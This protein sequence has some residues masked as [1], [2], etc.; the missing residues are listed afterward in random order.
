ML[1]DIKARHNT[2]DK[3]WQFFSELPRGVAYLVSHPAHRGG[4][5]LKSCLETVVVC[6]ILTLRHPGDLQVCL[7][8]RRI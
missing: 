3:H 7:F 2:H 4:L 1:L 6:C 5:M 8:S